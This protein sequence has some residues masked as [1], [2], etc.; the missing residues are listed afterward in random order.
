MYP[1]RRQNQRKRSRNAPR[2]NKGGA[3]RLPGTAR[4]LLPLIQPA[5]KALAQV[6]AGNTKASG[7][8]VHA[9][10]M[11]ERA[12]QMVAEKQLDRMSVRD[13][14]EFLE[15][16]ALLKL[17]VNDA[18]DEL[19]PLDVEPEDEGDDAQEGE[20]AGEEAEEPQPVD[21][22]AER[23]AAEAE[24]AR[25]EEEAREQRER[26]KRVALALMSPS[27]ETPI[28]AMPDLSP[29]EPPAED[30]PAPKRKRSESTTS[31][32]SAARATSTSAARR[33]RITLRSASR[34]GEGGGQPSDGDKQGVASES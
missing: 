11:V 15:Q 10:N 1:Y 27:P 23:A 32:R 19:G 21:E 29:F 30:L 18:E 26:L 9:R 16:L 34:E 31:T 5:T 6:L 12:D 20:E 2:R 17:T 14:E 3:R 8:F 28:E 4:E 24:R 7:Q 33:P 22:E 13:R 25:A